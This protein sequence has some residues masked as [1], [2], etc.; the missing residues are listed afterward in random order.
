MSKAH[1]PCSSKPSTS[2]VHRARKN[3]KHVPL[4]SGAATARARVRETIVEIV[5]IARGSDAFERV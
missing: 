4:A 5:D 3:I 2:A 1:L